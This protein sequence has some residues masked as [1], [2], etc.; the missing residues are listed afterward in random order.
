MVPVLNAENLWCK[1]FFWEVFLHSISPRNSHALQTHGS[2]LRIW[3]IHL[4]MTTAACFMM[5]NFNETH[6]D[7][8][9]TKGGCTQTWQCLTFP[10]DS[11]SWM[12]TNGFGA[13]RKP[14][15]DKVLNEWW[16]PFPV[17]EGSVWQPG[18][19]HF[20]KSYQLH[21]VLLGVTR[22]TD[23]QLWTEQWT[24]DWEVQLESWEYFD[25]TIHLKVFSSAWHI[26]KNVS[27]KIKF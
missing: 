11:S 15:R 20:P 26:I 4:Q 17:E 3:K 8:K 22:C 10:D 24:K 21:V 9:R 25:V 16:R 12:N 27:G 19:F 7:I 6:Q 18:H 1:Y 2:V 23:V 14:G 13:T 5:K